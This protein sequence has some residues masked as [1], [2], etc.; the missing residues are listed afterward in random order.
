MWEP[1]AKERSASRLSKGVIVSRACA[2][3][4]LHHWIV[5]SYEVLEEP[6]GPD[7]GWSGPGI[8]ER[9]LEKG[10]DRE[11]AAH[12][13][14]EEVPISP[15]ELLGG[16]GWRRIGYR[17]KAG[18]HRVV[19]EQS[20]A[21]RPLRL[22][23]RELAACELAALGRKSRHIGE[24]LGVAAATARGAIDR[25]IAKL[26]LA[27]AIQLP[28]L[29]YTLGA[30]AQRI[31][32]ERGVTHLV[33]ERELAVLSRHHLTP[34]ERVLVERVLLG[35]SYRGMAAY[36]NVSTRTV[37]NQL[38][39]LYD[40]FGVSGRAELVAALLAAPANPPGETG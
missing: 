7:S 30:P 22:T 4:A 18:V 37:A 23:R 15:G 5:V 25:S 9:L 26:R 8:F 11:N 29:W 40:R 24:G 20:A 16:S 27:S 17:L 35:D 33:F 10:I 19:C 13:G 2:S 39:R 28:L 38:S 6:I 3:Y 36:R 32:A 34:I 1:L 21:A 14:I 12:G 31:G